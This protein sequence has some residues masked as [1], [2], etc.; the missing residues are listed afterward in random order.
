M[1]FK[2]KILIE[3]YIPHNY[4]DNDDHRVWLDKYGDVI[5]RI[6]RNNEEVVFLSREAE[7]LLIT[8][9]FIPHITP[10]HINISITISKSGKIISYTEN[11]KEK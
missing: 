5:K 3:K 2:R 1:M 8:K 6:D 10:Q 7:C 4:V 11:E 9:F